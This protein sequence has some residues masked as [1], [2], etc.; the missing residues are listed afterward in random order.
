MLVAAR[1]AVMVGLGACVALG[2]CPGEPPPACITV[3]TT[4][5][6]QY[7]PTFDN[8]YDN[9]LRL[10]CGSSRGACHSASGEG[11]MSLADPVIAH[12]SLLAGRVKPGDPACSEM[13]VRTHHPG[14]DYEMPPGAPLAEAERC[15]LLQWVLAGAPGPGEPLP[16]WRPR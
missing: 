16:A 15:A 7:V 6:P 5:A 2:G 4:C 12:A 13:I 9:T 8:V 1:R 10:D 11:G 14:R 3:D